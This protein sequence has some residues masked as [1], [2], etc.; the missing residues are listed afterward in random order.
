MNSNIKYIDIKEASILTQKSEL[1]IRRLIK[2][3]KID[4]TKKE[5]KYLINQ[6]SLW[7]I[8]PIIKNI[9]IKEEKIDKNENIIDN[10]LI[11]QLVEKH[12]TPL[13][14]RVTYLYNENEKY[15]KLLKAGDWLIKEKEL[16]FEKKLKKYKLWLII[17]YSIIITWLIILFFIFLI[18]KWI[19]VF[20]F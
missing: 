19:L 13:L 5:S 4:Y 8:Y 1:S 18:L 17:A 3:N 16:E 14:D 2:N 9:D 15:Q 11:N 12:V 7:K 6:D 10:N 20:N